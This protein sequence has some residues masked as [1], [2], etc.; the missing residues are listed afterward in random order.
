[1]QALTRILLH[2][3]D[4]TLLSF[5]LSPLLVTGMGELKLPPK[6]DLQQVHEAHGC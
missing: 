5:L 2:H 4:M 6:A 1:M 3:L